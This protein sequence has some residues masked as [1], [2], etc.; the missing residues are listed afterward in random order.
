M[1]VIST[2]N[3]LMFNERGLNLSFISCLSFVISNQNKGRI[4]A[5]KQ[6]SD[7]EPGQIFIEV[8]KNGIINRNTDQL[9][10]N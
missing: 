5:S 1:F 9:K 4:E 8:E 6:I 10:L 3:N 2:S 7:N